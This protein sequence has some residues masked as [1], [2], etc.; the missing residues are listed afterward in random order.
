MMRTKVSR[1]SS[2]ANIREDNGPTYRS[3][4]N[5]RCKFVGFRIVMGVR[6]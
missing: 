5:F 2:W 1:G 6:R 3:Y 4:R